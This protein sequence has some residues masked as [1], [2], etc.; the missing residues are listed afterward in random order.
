MPYFNKLA[1]LFCIAL[2]FSSCS[3]VKTTYPIAWQV[4]HDPFDKIHVLLSDIHYAAEKNIVVFTNPLGTNIYDAQTGKLKSLQTANR[5]TFRLP[6][7]NKNTP[8]IQYTSKTVYVYFPDGQYLLKFDYSTATESISLIDVETNEVIW[9]NTQITWSLERIQELTQFTANMATK[10]LGV[11]AGATAAAGIFFPE[12]Y[13]SDVI[14][15]F[16]AQDKLL[17]KDYDALSRGISCLDLKTGKLL[18]RTKISANISDVLIDPTETFAIFY[19]GDPGIL[20]GLGNLAQI[21]KDLIKL[22]LS[23]GEV[24]WKSKYNRSFTS[25]LPGNV[26]RIDV[27]KFADIRLGNDFIFSNFNQIEVHDLETGDSRFVTQTG[28][29]AMMNFTGFGPNVFFPLPIIEDEVLYRTVTNRVL[30]FNQ[31]YIVE[32]YDIRTGTLLWTSEE[33]SKHPPLNMKLS[34]NFLVV[35]FGGKTGTKAIDKNTGKEVWHYPMSKHAH[36]SVMHIYNDLVL[37]PESQLIHILDLKTG[38]LKKQI[39]LKTKTGFINTS[40][41]YGDQLVIQGKKKGIALINP[42]TWDLT[43]HQPVKFEYTLHVEGDQFVVNGLNVS[44]PLFIFKSQNL[45]KL[46]AVKRNKKRYALTW[47]SPSNTVYEG[48][49]GRIIKYA[50][51]E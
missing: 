15:P 27:D 18:W 7:R 35:G 33:L 5:K 22:D 2:L 25:K 9:K 24:I 8:P 48:T 21:N 51:H 30:A 10:N 37:A 50:H 32:A 39:D 1:V 44:D 3:S 19:G 42:E 26:G 28:R 12:K 16:P 36:K 43:A 11:R 29:D 41:F 45:E 4:K 46:G 47:D 38:V 40:F 6:I 14:V 31:T 13:I 34:G 49:K 17:I 23:T 20:D